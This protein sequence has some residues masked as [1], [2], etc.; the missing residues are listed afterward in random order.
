MLMNLK[1]KIALILIF[2]SDIS[3]DELTFK[4]KTQNFSQANSAHDL[5]LE[6]KMDYNK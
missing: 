1:C 5:D 3:G 2:R 6:M 4:G